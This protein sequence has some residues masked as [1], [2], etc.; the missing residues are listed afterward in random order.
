[1]LSEFVD[2]RLES[3]G[4]IGT[5]P[6]ITTALRYRWHDSTA[7]GIFGIAE[8]G[9]YFN[10]SKHEAVVFYI[11]YMMIQ[12]SFLF[13]FYRDFSVLILYGMSMHCMEIFYTGVDK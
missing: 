6:D 9:L 2:G 5:N 3:N 12:C 7:L 11:F 8:A 4:T 1:L 10:G 13:T